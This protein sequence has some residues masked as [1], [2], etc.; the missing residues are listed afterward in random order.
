MNLFDFA[1]QFIA[2][3]YENVYRAGVVVPYTTHL[4]GVARLLKSAGYREE[5]VIAGLLHDCLEDGR[6]DEREL[7]TFF[8][9]EIAKLV[10][11][12]TEPDKNIVWEQ[13]KKEV[14]NTIQH[15]T[16]EQLAIVLAEK[17]HNVRAITVEVAQLG[18]QVWANLKAPKEKQEWYY[19]SIIEKVKIYHPNAVLLCQLEQAVEKL[20]IRVEN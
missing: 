15:K 7:R 6:A 11:V 13:R 4:F 16:D 2:E 20:F 5:V 3:K 18:E 19:R 14:L 8:G 9:D 10:K 17:T 1:T 12:S